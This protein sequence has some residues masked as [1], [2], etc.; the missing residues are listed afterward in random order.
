MT[1]W[2]KNVEVHQLIHL[3]SNTCAHTPAPSV[4]RRQKDPIHKHISECSPQSS[5]TALVSHNSYCS[6]SVG[7]R[8]C[9]HPHGGT[10][11]SGSSPDV[12]VRL[13]SQSSWSSTS[14]VDCQTWRLWRLQLNIFNIAEKSWN[15]TLSCFKDMMM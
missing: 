14:E 5:P 8:V 4:S 7:Q 3:L 1:R 9:A 2:N 11:R 12:F 15:F 6:T 10:R 13:C